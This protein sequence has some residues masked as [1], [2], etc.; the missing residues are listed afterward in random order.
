MGLNGR[1]LHCRQAVAAAAVAALCVLA[2][3]PVCA[4]VQSS[5]PNILLIVADDLGFS[6]LG[7]Y[8]SEIATPNL[9]KLAAEGVRFSQFYN[10]TRC[11]PSRASLLTGLYAHKAGVGLMVSDNGTSFPA[12]RGFLTT[13]SLTLAEALKPAGYRT[14]MVGKW[15][16]SQKV[17]PVHRGF[18]E[19]YGML[20]GINHFFAEKPGY[21]RLP[22]G[23]P[24]RQY[25]AGKFY[26]TDVF[27]DYALDFINDARTSASQP[28]FLYLAFSAP[29]FPLHALPEDIAKYASMYQQGW[30]KIREGRLER[31]KRLGLIDADT[32]LPPRSTIPP[33]WVADPHGWSG[34][35]NPAWESIQPARQRDLARRMAVYAA[36]VDRLDQNVGRVL[37]DLRAHGDLDNTIVLF[38][39]DN[40][41]CAEWDPWGFDK[42]SGTDNVLHTEAEL[43]DM[44]GPASYLS[45]GSGWANASNTPLRLYKHYIHEGGISSPLIVHWPAQLKADGAWRKQAGHVIDVMPTLLE[46][47][48]VSYPETR[49]GHELPALAGVSL[50]PA[51]RGEPLQRE[52]LAWEHE[53]NRGIRV[54][55]W[56]LVSVGANAWEL[57]DMRKDRLELLNRA[58]AEPDLVKQMSDKWDLWAAENQV[59][60]QPALKP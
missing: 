60:P 55:D 47:A 14:Y 45:Y 53:G 24:V 58:D 20:G 27:G 36:M 40:G 12:Y 46:V 16:L 9:D 54:G 8:G 1:Q 17:T 28:W 15:H 51:L 44:G 3:M 33:N 30:D 23:R 32:T 48:G 49:S 39:S 26:A 31:Q 5:K 2:A 59:L 13:N 11:C 19:F 10:G 50:L 29:H 52:Y 38:L 7:C 34:K 56:K 43:D 41:A 42:S 21:R 35:E 18:D 25:D 57:Y 37:E 4:V 22:E 6:D